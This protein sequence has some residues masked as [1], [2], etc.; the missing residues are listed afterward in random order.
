M[1]DQQAIARRDVLKTGVGAC[2]LVA[3]PGLAALVALAQEKHVSTSTANDQV[4]P[5]AASPAVVKQGAG[6]PGEFDFLA[7]EWKIKHRRLKTPGPSAATKEWDEFEGEATCFTILAGVGSVEELRIPS[8]GFS[9]MG[10]RLLDV[11]NKVWNDFW[12][13]AKS[14][15]LTTP[16]QT[17]GFE[18]GVGTFGADDMDGDKPIK[19]KGVWDQ[20]T[21]N[22]CRWW[23]AVSWDDGKT[24]EENWVMEWT[25]VK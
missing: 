18:N 14:G 12:V 7:G 22:S 21:P 6:K 3:T 1:N 4:Q 15:V 17:G 10:L 13:N 11:E 2:V 16:G 24:W 20:I 8:R 23:Q 19:V 5:E 9:G 25:R